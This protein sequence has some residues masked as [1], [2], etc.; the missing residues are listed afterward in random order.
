MKKPKKIIN[1]SVAFLIISALILIS[2]NAKS[3]ITQEIQ[4]ITSENP[5]SV[6][7]EKFSAKDPIDLPVNL[8]IKGM[9]ST[10]EIIATDKDSNKILLYN[11]TT[12]KQTTIIEPLNKGYYIKNVVSNSDWI[13]W[14][15]N[16]VLIQDSS[17]KPFKWVIVAKNVKTG[18]VITVDKSTL[19]NNKYNIPLFVNFTPDNLSLSKENRV[20]YARNDLENSQ[21][22]SELILYDLNT[23]ISKTISKSKEVSTELIYLPNIYGDKVA[24]SLFRDLNDDTDRNK[25]FRNTQFKYSDIYIYDIKTDTTKQLTKDDFYHAPS[26]FGD[27]MVAIHTPLNRDSYSEVVLFNLKTGDEKSIINENS[28]IEKADI[29]KSIYRDHP[30]INENFICWFNTGGFNNR[31]IF[32][33]KNQKFIELYKNIDDDH[34]SIITITG[35]LDNY[36]FMFLRSLNNNVRRNMY[37]KAN[38]YLD[39]T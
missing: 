30:V 15:E 9:I 21:V 34:Q 37:I 14:V 32:D 24:W 19:T 39:P 35:M 7:A 33:Y 22:I 20:V 4:N 27:Y 13:V 38:L 26:M 3:G 31:F 29:A 1:I 25:T 6:T 36:V 28:L 2:M 8:L 23:K 17:D 5:K 10:N 11:L 12:K 16:E 18:K